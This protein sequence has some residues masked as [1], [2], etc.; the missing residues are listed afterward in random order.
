MMQAMIA[1]SVPMQAVDNIVGMPERKSVSVF[2]R[3]TEKEKRDV[4]RFAKADRRKV[5]DWVR[6]II[7]DEVSRR[8]L[9]ALEQKAEESP[10]E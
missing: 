7:L 3:L 6:G 2:V 4:Q 1:I 10:G 8:R 9:A 5:A